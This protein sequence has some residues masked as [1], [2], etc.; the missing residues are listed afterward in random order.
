VPVRSHEHEPPLVE[1]RGVGIADCDPLKWHAPIQCRCL[2]RR[3]I[4]RIRTEAQQN[5]TAPKKG[6]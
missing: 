4:G 5:K 2:K 1:L 6:R 3:T